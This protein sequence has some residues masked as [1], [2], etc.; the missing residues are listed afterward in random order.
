MGMLC[1]FCNLNSYKSRKIQRGFK[2]SYTGDA[3]ATY[4]IIEKSA[5][6]SKAKITIAAKEYTGSAVT[7]EKD[8]FTTFTLG[9]TPLTLGTDYEIVSYTNNVKKGTASVTVRGINS[10]GG[11]KTVKFKIGAKVLK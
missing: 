4:R 9:G 3:D 1:L 8:D 10:C 6:I 11:M 2:I 7:L 5:D